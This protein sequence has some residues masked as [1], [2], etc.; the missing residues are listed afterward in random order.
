MI[1][2]IPLPVLRAIPAD[3]APETQA[4]I[5]SVDYVPAVKIAFQA[6]RQILGAG[7]RDLRRHLLDRARY[8]PGLVPLRRYPP[9][10]GHSARCLY[11]VGRAGREVHHHAARRTC[12]G[13]A[14]GWRTATSRL[15][16]A[17]DKRCVRCVEERPIQR[18]RLGRV[19]PRRP[20]GALRSAV[21]RR[22]PVPVCGRAPVL[23]QR[24]AG[25]RSA[26]G[27]SRAAGNR[28]TNARAETL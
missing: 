4:A 3:F 16:T 27:A 19:E 24:L 18:G 20:R 23:R 12:G 2:T 22:W 5:A 28:R 10:K 17:S 8:H 21:E 26:F 7:C 11:L 14:G 13:R 15:P 1:V 6:E 9:A 25:G